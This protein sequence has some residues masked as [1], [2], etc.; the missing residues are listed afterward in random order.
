MQLSAAAQFFGMD[1]TQKDVLLG[2]YVNAA[3]F[4]VGA[5]SALIVSVPSPS[6]L[7]ATLFLKSVWLHGGHGDFGF[8]A[9][10][11]SSRGLIGGTLL[12]HLAH[13][14]LPQ[15]GW[16]ADRYNRRNMLFVVALTGQIP[17]LCTIFVSAAQEIEGRRAVSVAQGYAM[18]LWG[19]GQGREWSP[20]HV[21]DA[22]EGRAW[23][24]GPYMGRRVVYG[25]QGDIWGA[26]QGCLGCRTERG[27]PFLVQ[28]EGRAR[29]GRWVKGDRRAEDVAGVKSVYVRRC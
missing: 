18:A 21:W 1:S 14:C 5:P 23:S 25:T 13:F 6:H 4:A 10:Y 12:S 15:V 27:R 29:A 3:F 17:C 28:E 2:G 9:C 24:T 11:L 22:G 19:A 26:G 16:L 7:A 20:G 8:T